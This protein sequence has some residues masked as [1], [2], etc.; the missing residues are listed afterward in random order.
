MNGLGCRRVTHFMSYKKKITDGRADF[1]KKSVLVLLMGFVCMHASA[2]RKNFILRTMDWGYK[3]VQGDSAKPYKKYYFAVPI[4]AYR[5]ESKWILG[6][7]LAHIFR[8]QQGDQITRPSIIRANVS[9]SQQHQ[10][11]FRPFL[12]IFSKMNRLNI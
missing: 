2:Q 1:F 4:V 7:S 5:P 8:T 6:I 11:A 9:Y 12:E 10:F 3:I